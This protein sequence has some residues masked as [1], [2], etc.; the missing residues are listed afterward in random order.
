MSSVLSEPIPNL[1]EF[2]VEKSGYRAEISD[3]NN[4][5]QLQTTTNNFLDSSFTA[6][7]AVSPKIQLFS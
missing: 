6:V 2:S 1:S 7:L 3:K 5:K 4:Y